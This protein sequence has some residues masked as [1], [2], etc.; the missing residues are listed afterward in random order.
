MTEPTKETRA[1][2]PEGVATEVLQFI[3]F[4][5]ENTLTARDIGAVG[6]VVEYGRVHA[7]VERLKELLRQRDKQAQD[8]AAKVEKLKALILLTDP[9]VS[10]EE[11][12]TLSCKQW[13]AYCNAFPQK[14]SQ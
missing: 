13:Q 3:L 12:N 1:E 5:K 11:M 9:A 6:M 8:D 2:L 10:N 14:D 7:E 4:I